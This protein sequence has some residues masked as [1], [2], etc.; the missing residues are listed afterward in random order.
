M[1]RVQ[2]ALCMRGRN[3]AI[4]MEFNAWVRQS[5]S[6]LLR[7]RQGDSTR[8]KSSDR[9]RNCLLPRGLLKVLHVFPDFTRVETSQSPFRYV[10]GLGGVSPEQEARWLDW[11]E[12]D[13]PWELTEE[14]FYEQYEFAIVSEGQ[15]IVSHDLADKTMLGSLRCL[16]SEHFRCRFIDRV[17]VTAHM[18]VPGQTIRIHNDYLPGGETHRLLLQVNRRWEPSHGGILMFFHGPTPETVDRLIEPR[19]GSIQAFA[20]SPSSYHAVSTVHSGKR[21]TVVYSFFSRKKTALRSVS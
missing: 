16:M 15:T 20:I 5:V 14:D 18:L 13:A 8:D 12:N 19:S 6:L 9:I 1:S 4:S 21:F 2:A 17:D 7:S 10:V 3:A 11:L